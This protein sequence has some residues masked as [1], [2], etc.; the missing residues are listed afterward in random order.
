MVHA[1]NVASLL[2][3]RPSNLPCHMHLALEDCDF[4][5][6]Y[7]SG[8]H[9]SRDLGPGSLAGKL[10]MKAAVDDAP[11]VALDDRPILEDQDS[12][13]KSLVRLNLPEKLTNVLIRPKRLLQQL[14][15]LPSVADVRVC[16]NGICKSRIPRIEPYLFNGH[17]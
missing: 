6:A 16:Q 7:L 4:A 3:G 1:V 10:L 12:L 2:E 9:S 17:F 14:L 5:S 13:G 8:Q 11:A 15:Q